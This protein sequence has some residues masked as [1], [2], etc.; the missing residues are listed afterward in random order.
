MEDTS[1]SL[2]DGFSSLESQPSSSAP[3]ST[4]VLSE[5]TQVSQSEK[6]AATVEGSTVKQSDELPG[7]PDEGESNE[8]KS[9]QD[10]TLKTPPADTPTP[11][12][13]TEESKSTTSQPGSCTETK[14]DNLSDL[15]TD[16]KKKKGTTK[17]P[18]VDHNDTKDSK[19]KK[20]TTKQPTVDQNANVEP[21]P[22][23]TGQTKQKGKSQ[24]DQKR[25]HQVVC[26]SQT[27]SKAASTGTSVD[28][29]EQQSESGQESTSAE[30]SDGDEESKPGNKDDTNA[31]VPAGPPPKRSTRSQTIA[32]CDRLTIYFHAVLSKDFKFDQNEDRIFVRA[33]LCIGTWEDNAVE[34][35]VIRD[36]GEHGFL[37]EGSL[38]T[39]KNNTISTS[40]PYKYVV[41][42]KKKKKYEYEY[43]YKLDSGNHT[44]NRCLFVKPRFLNDD[45]DW[46]QYDD[47]I[48]AEPSKNI[49]KRFTDKIWP[50]QRKS[51]IQGR[52]IAGK[53]M[54]ET[55]FDL[56]RSW[57]DTNLRSFIFQLN[58]FF[59]V[60]G[61]PYVY[62]EKEKKWHSLDYGPKDVGKMLK[63]FMLNYVI[64]Q[65]Q[66]DGDGKSHYIQDPMR[67]AVIMLCVRKQHQLNLDKAELHRLCSALCLPKLDRDGFL[68]Y[69]ADFSQHVSV[70]KE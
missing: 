8:Q 57:T 10:Q 31:N 12:L 16:T 3:H 24:Q 2:Q 6:T 15:K 36:L 56:L 60:Y 64:P 22:K 21:N 40:I 52:E 18:T 53:I 5:D 65:L 70:F 50:D 1:D 43:I 66:K 33:G 34:L 39:N 47:I 11:H 23:Q 54:L 62:E 61:E 45:G 32:A 38:V 7:K 35:S 13:V 42:R 14:A 37:V 67:A 69:W 25:K 27:S 55:I 49:I 68:Q 4:A 20:D 9:N 58:Q 51:L 30:T 46:H 19:N 48:C 26:D 63:E 59:E 28:P 29:Q 41:Y 44:T 17:Q